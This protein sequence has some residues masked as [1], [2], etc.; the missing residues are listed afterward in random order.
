MIGDEPMQYEAERIAAAHDGYAEVGRREGLAVDRRRVDND[1]VQIQYLVDGDSASLT[2]V[3][4]VPGFVNPA[5]MWWQEMEALRPRRTV[6]VS[7]RGRGGSDAPLSGYRFEHQL[8]DLVAVMDAE[9]LEGCAI[10]AWSRGVPLAVATA[11]A[12]P[13][14]VHGLVLIDHPPV[15]APLPSGWVDQA[16]ELAPEHPQA[17]RGLQREAVLVDLWDRLPELG[18]LVLVLYGGRPDDALLSTTDAQRY[19]ET[20]PR[21]EVICL[22]DAGHDVR[23]PDRQRFM[24]ALRTFLGRVDRD[25]RPARFVV[26]R[27]E[28]ADVERVRRVAIAAW[29]DTYAGLLRA[30]TIEAFLERAYAAGRLGERITD[31]EFLV[32]EREG[33]MAAF[34]DSVIQP[35][36]LVLAAIYAVPE[37]RGSGAGT[38]LLE[39]IEARHPDLPFAADVLLG[40][41]KGELFYKRHGFEPRD[42]IEGSLFGEPIVE[43]RWWRPAARTSV[44]HA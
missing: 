37:A 3:L 32:A 33:E 14:R 38:A 18:C 43:R 2:P 22:A 27:A 8:S 34:A 12:Q 15:Y 11:L 25:Q 10:V 7:L 1:G 20:L 31:D 42:R 17:L 6:A 40:N 24:A 21:G 26:R 4:F 39:A 16:M 35:D 13:T 44:A 29:R 28:S 30:E 36:R 5:S 9:Q 41:R 19:S 23:E